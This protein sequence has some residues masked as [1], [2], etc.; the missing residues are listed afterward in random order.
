MYTLQL[1]CQTCFCVFYSIEDATTYKGKW[2][3][4]TGIDVEII[5]M[6]SY[7][8]EVVCPVID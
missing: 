6:P 1:P 2:H 3:E 4:K 8:T 7:I 5:S